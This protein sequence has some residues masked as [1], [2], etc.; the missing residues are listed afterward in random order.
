MANEQ[1][2]KQGTGINWGR[3]LERDA[4]GTADLGATMTKL[5]A[6]ARAYV[7][8]NEV[9]TERIRG[10][11]ATVYEQNPKVSFDLGSL[12]NRVVTEMK[13]AAGSESKIGE[14]VKGFIRGESKAFEAGE[15][16]LYHIARGKLGGVRRVTAEY[17]EAF[18]KAQAKKAADAQ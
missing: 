5:E 3:I 7:V 4:H 17:T 2:D 8:A 13:V 15:G 6:E 11:V 10:A 18:R 12:T 16:G 9:P 14:A 1:N